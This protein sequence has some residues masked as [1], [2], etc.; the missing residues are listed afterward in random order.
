[1][2]GLT[3]LMLEI[4]SVASIVTIV[5]WVATYSYLEPTWRKGPIGRSLVEFAVYAMV[6]PT[7]FLLSLFFHFNRQSSQ[8]LAWIEIALLL[9][10]IPFGMIRRIYIWRRVSKIGTTGRLPAGHGE[11]V[12]Q[13][14]RRSNADSGTQPI[15]PGRQRPSCSDDAGGSQSD[16]I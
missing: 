3:D 14:E 5:A 4:G 8:V 6:T 7:L 2:E 13:K 15:D 12:H 9:V 11:P 16:Q 1:M 10:L